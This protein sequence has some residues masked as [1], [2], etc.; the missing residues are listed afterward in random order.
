MYTIFCVD[1][2]NKME[3][4]RSRFCSTNKPTFNL[5]EMGRSDGCRIFLRS[6]CTKFNSLLYPQ[7]SYRSLRYALDMTT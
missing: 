7:A 2:E 5:K 6:G 3:G 4:S 1:T